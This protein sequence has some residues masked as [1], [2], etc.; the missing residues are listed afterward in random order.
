MSTS[1]K[2]RPLESMYITH[3]SYTFQVYHFEKHHKGY[4][5]LSRETIFPFGTGSSDTSQGKYCKQ[6]RCKLSEFIIDE[7]LIKVGSDYV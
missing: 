2:D 7:T 3:Y 1:K 6:T 5:D 4:L